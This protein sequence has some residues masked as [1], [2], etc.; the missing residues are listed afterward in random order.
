[1]VQRG[2]KGKE[3]TVPF[4]SITLF[5]GNTRNECLPSMNLMTSIHPFE[6]NL[7]SASM[8]QAQC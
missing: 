2:Q 5:L 4:L 7:L 3:L 8:C 6:E 1:M